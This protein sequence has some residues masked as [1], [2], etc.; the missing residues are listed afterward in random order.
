GK[1]RFLNIAYKFVDLITDT[2]GPQKR[3][4]YPGHEEIELGLIELYR[5]TSNR[6]YFELAKFFIEQRGSR[7]SPLQTELEN[8]DE[9]AGGKR[10]KKA[11]HKLY[12]NEEGEY[13]GK[14]VQDHRP[15]QE[16]EKLVGHAVR[17]T[18]FYSAV[19][20]I[21]METGDQALIQALHRLWYN[22]RKKRM[23][24]TGGIGS[25]H[26][27]EG[28]SS[29]FD[30]PNETAYAETCAAIGNIMWNHRMFLLTKEAQFIDTLERVLYNGLLSGVSLDGK[31][32]FM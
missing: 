10:R 2:F 21:A 31:R 32:F 19:A 17:A 1:K 24:I 14:Y 25:L 23:Y 9:Q 30:L 26:D 13:D 18:Y 5:V 4:S 22:M 3:F 16:Q 29:N 20:D 15:V 6:S 11:Y 27:I 28:F 8:L 12:F 7:P